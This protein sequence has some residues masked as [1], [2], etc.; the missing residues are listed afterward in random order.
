[1]QL[2]PHRFQLVKVEL[3]DVLALRGAVRI[4][5]AVLFQIEPDELASVRLGDLVA[6]GR[7]L[8]W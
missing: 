2:R 1:M 8:K 3:L 7:I 4:A 6:L 5:L